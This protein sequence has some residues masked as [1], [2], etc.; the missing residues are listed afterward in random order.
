MGKTTLPQASGIG[1]ACS[2]RS[3]PLFQPEFITLF[4]RADQVRWGI[5]SAAQIARRNWK[6]ILKTGNSVVTAVASRDIAKAREFIAECQ[7]QAPMP[8]APLAFGSY[9]EL[10]RSPDIDAVYIPLPTGVRKEWVIQAAQAGKHVVCEKP[11]AVS[12]ADLREMIE[13]CRRHKV[14]FMDGVMFMHSARLKRIRECLDH[15]DRI[16]RLKRITSTFNFYG[17]PE[18]VAQNIRTNSKLE[19]YGC[20]G[21]L[22]WYCIRL[23]LWTMKEKLPEAVTGRTISQDSGKNSPEG[24]PTEFSGEL[25]F[26]GGVSASF[27]CSFQTHTE[28]WAVISGERGSLRI[29]DFVLPIFGNEIGFEIDQSDLSISGCDFNMESRVEQVNIPEYGSGHPTAQDT[30]LF[31]NFAN[32]ILSGKLNDD[33]PQIALNTQ[34]VM[35]AC[36]NSAR[37]SGETT[38]VIGS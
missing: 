25:F 17:G 22:G 23:A 38:K 27:Y 28:E 33:W 16:G 31:R 29:P 6:A 13:A 19:P 18:F 26:P 30:N 5:L 8:N 15:S 1:E 32:Q 11:C 35:E 21:D 37:N 10:L 2:I 4:M 9:D 14:Q 20:L 7:Q 24:V 12:M 36:A 34:L 3:N